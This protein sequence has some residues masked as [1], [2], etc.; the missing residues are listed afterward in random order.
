AQV[1]RML[2]LSA[3]DEKDVQEFHKVHPDAKRKGF[4]RLFRSPTLFEDV[5]KS[6]LLC[7]CT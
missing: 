3:K 4:G 2:R 5:V 7:N 6:M 1:A